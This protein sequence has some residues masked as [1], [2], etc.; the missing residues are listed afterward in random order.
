MGAYSPVPVAGDDVVERVMATAIRPTLHALAARG[1]EYRGILYAGLMLT[2]EGP[3]IVE[4]NVRFGD[5]EC[6]VVVPRLTT[7]LGALCMASARGEPLPPVR[8]SADAWV[9]IVLASE[10]YPASPRKGDVIEGL[11]A[12][13]AV[14]G[15][16]VFHAGTARDLDGGVVT[17]GGRV[18]DVTA[19]APTLVEARERAYAA[20]EL[21]EWPGVHFRRDIAAE[22]AKVSA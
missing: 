6:Q 15:V 9:T 3:K 11:P 20:A 17:D 22:A 14:P 21:I 19:S 4:Y 10:G 1:I 8:F 13:S 12:A 2:P 16:V 18:L 7:D 5:P